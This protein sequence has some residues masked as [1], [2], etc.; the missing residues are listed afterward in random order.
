MLLEIVCHPMFRPEMG[1]DDAPGAGA[2]EPP[3]VGGPLFDGALL[4]CEEGQ[5]ATA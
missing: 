1:V 5:T 4:A 3:G 2:L